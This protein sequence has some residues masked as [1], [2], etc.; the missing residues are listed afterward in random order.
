MD[1][2][3]F[4]NKEKKH[5]RYENASLYTLSMVL[6]GLSLAMV[7]SLIWTLYD[8]DP[9]RVFLWPVIFAFVSG[10]V[11]LSL[12]R[13]PDHVNPLTGLFML[14]MVWFVSV[15]FGSMPFMLAGMAPVD[16]IFES[17]S[18][19][20][21]TGATIMSDIESW[22]NGIL[23]WR[24]MTQWIGGIA[25]I[26]IFLLLMPMVGFGKIGRASCRERV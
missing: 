11:L 15:V 23:L 17:C 6:L 1:R 4:R 26:V 22:S 19:F 20:T 2:G 13:M 10:T 5:L 24:S 21:T 16:A 14:G 18:G 8:G 25:I 12:V 3:V 7:P 9:Y